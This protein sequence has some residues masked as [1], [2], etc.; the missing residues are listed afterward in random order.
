MKQTP[1]HRPYLV[2]ELESDLGSRRVLNTRRCQK[3]KEC[4]HLLC[5]SMGD[6]TVI[7]PISTNPSVAFAGIGRNRCG[8]LQL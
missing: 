3:A 4:I 6:P 8:S 7:G 5:R 1:R 2:E